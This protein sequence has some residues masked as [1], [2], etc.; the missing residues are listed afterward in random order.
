VLYFQHHQF[1]EEKE[2]EEHKYLFF[3]FREKEKKGERFDVKC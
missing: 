2:T 1:P 3:T